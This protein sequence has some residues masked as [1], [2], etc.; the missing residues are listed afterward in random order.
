MT[1][2][3][4]SGHVLAQSASDQRSRDLSGP[5]VGPSITFKVRPFPCLSP[6]FHINFRDGSGCFLTLTTPNAHSIRQ[7]LHTSVIPSTITFSSTALT[8][9]PILAK[10]SLRK[11]PI[12]C[13][14][15][16]HTP[17]GMCCST[18]GLS[19]LIKYLTG[20]GQRNRGRRR[21]YG[22]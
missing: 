16:V 20:E 1:Q 18:W 2:E 19:Q 17:T 6:I 5:S 22:S 11:E 7:L 8:W 21:S 13:V 12:K 14:V 9:A 4:N 15:K 10:S 3:W